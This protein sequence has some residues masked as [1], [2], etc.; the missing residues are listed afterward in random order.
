MTSP[1]KRRVPSGPSMVVVCVQ[2]A[3]LG[4]QVRSSEIPLQSP[5]STPYLYLLLTVPRSCNGIGLLTMPFL[6]MFFLV[7]RPPLQVLPLALVSSWFSLALPYS[8]ALQVRTPDFL[9]AELA[10]G[11]C[12]ANLFF[13]L[14]RF[15]SF[16]WLFSPGASLFRP[17]VLVGPTV[18]CEI[19]YDSDFEEPAYPV[20]V[21]GPKLPLAPSAAGPSVILLNTP[22]KFGTGKYCCFLLCRSLSWCA[23]PYRAYDPLLFPGPVPSSSAQPQRSVIQ[24]GAPTG[25]EPLQAG[26]FP[27]T[28]AK[29]CAGEL[30]S[31][32][33][34][35]CLSTVCTG[36]G[37]IRL[38]SHPAGCICCLCCPRNS[39]YVFFSTLMRLLSTATPRRVDAAPL[40]LGTAHQAMPNLGNGCFWGFLLSLMSVLL[41]CISR[42]LLHDIICYQCPCSTLMRCWGGI[43]RNQFRPLTRGYTGL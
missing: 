18:P 42:A 29:F 4:L 40:I 6:C 30:Y 16:S 31:I 24:S 7:R 13:P 32:T 35:H 3:P 27:T 9:G 33:C 38:A 5:V 39:W 8:S 23:R 28:P 36:R 43:H 20:P 37:L 22:T 25:Y 41:F 15:P 14:S 1:R 17:S 12:A 19:V 11:R 34:Y 10:C 2:G 21:L 26:A